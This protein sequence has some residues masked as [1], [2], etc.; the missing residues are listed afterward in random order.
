MRLGLAIDLYAGPNR[1]QDLDLEALRR[2]IG[3]QD[4]GTE[5][6]E[7]FLLSEIFASILLEVNKPQD[8]EPVFRL[9]ESL[10]EHLRNCSRGKV[11]LSRSRP[12]TR[13]EQIV[14]S[15]V[16]RAVSD[17]AAKPQAPAVLD[18]FV[19]RLKLALRLR[20][21]IQQLGHTPTWVDQAVAAP[22]SHVFGLT[23]GRPVQVTPWDEATLRDH[24]AFLREIDGRLRECLTEADDRDR[25]F[26]GLYLPLARIPRFL[27][28]LHAGRPDSLAVPGLDGSG[29]ERQREETTV[30]RALR[31]S[32]RK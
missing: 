21:L 2:H 29:R 28:T 3:D 10:V 17:L 12:L 5:T 8:A 16:L 24:A 20:G 6:E 32:G 14:A 7:S 27:K 31:N 15:D 26:Q 13:L 18:H 1:D 30:R 25:V 11:N 9:S 4:Q 22:R 23:E 19:S